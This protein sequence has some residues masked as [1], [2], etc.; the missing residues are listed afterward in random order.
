MLSLAPC[1][2]GGGTNLATRLGSVAVLDRAKVPS[3]QGKEVPAQM[4]EPE[5][6]KQ[7]SFEDKETSKRESLR[8]GVLKG[9]QK[10]EM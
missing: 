9:P 5:S 4:H 7:V 8:L 6:R 2:A 1:T 3:H 10:A